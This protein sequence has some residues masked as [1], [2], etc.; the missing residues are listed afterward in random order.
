[1]NKLER[2]AFAFEMR[3]EG[4]SPRIVG[5][6]ALFNTEADLGS[7]RESIAPGAFATAIQQDDVRALFNHDPNYV[8]GRN[9][10]GTLRMSEDEKGLAVE[11]DPP[12]TQW[13][14][15]LQVSMRRGDITQ[16][17]FGFIAKEQRVEKRDGI[18][19][20]V[21]T[22]AQLFDVSPV[23]YPAYKQTDVAVRSA[24]DIFDEITEELRT[25]EAPTE[26]LPSEP[27]P[28]TQPEPEPVDYE[29]ILEV[30]RKRLQLIG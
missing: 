8:L 2:R 11:I 28:A 13:A 15:D 17:S 26:T 24:Q 27:I 23:T 21:I 29:A 22:R 5:H 16:M 19:H 10:A 14:S 6:A 4:D 25:T 3:A 7:F 18:I 12:A 1:M 30:Q 20:R 9:T